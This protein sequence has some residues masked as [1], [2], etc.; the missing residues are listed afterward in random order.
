VS[1][2]AESV[3]GSPYAGIVSRLLA[4]VADVAV[5]TVVA[6]AVQTLP[7]LAW[8]AVRPTSAPGWFQTGMSLL[9][10]LIP[11][12]YFTSWWA[13]TGQTPGDLAVGI[14]VEHR[15]GH[16][17]SVLHAAVRAAVGLALAPLWLLG[18]IGVLWDR[19][20]RAWHDR[21]LHTDVRYVPKQKPHGRRD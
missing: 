11:F 1:A 21:L 13:L 8:D 15:D 20:R 14:V 18:L 7:V 5:I 2:S 9:A 6:V 3:G 16:R 19:R 17:L 12:L 10:A 4:L